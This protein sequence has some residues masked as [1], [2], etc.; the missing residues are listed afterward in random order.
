MDPIAPLTGKVGEVNLFC[1]RD[2]FYSKELVAGVS[3]P[4]FVQ[5]F[6][7]G[8]ERGIGH[9]VGQRRS[10]GMRVFKQHRLEQHGTDVFLVVINNLLGKQLLDCLCYGLLVERLEHEKA[11]NLFAQRFSPL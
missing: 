10:P 8:G 2:L 9:K 4:E 3:T 11:G 5:P 6:L 7:I 1:W